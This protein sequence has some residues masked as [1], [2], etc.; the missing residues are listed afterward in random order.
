MQVIRSY[1]LANKLELIFTI[2]RVHVQLPILPQRSLT[3]KVF[4]I[5]YRQQLGV[6]TI[7]KQQIEI[8]LSDAQNQ[9]TSWRLF[10]RHL[11]DIPCVQY[12]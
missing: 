5:M 6:R 7:C 11:R 10:V 12:W 9:G 4:G 1:F 3:E 8:L 2:G